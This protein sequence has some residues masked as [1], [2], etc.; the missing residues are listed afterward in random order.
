MEVEDLRR[1]KSLLQ[2]QLREVKELLK[3]SMRSNNSFV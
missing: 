1:E 3:L 2:V